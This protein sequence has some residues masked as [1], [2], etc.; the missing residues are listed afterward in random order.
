VVKRVQGNVKIG[1]GVEIEIEIGDRDDKGA[2]S[3]GD[4]G[5]TGGGLDEQGAGI[6]RRI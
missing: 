4:L 6:L 5:M 2:D 1:N 3:S